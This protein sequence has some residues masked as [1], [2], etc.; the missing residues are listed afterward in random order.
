MIRLQQVTARVGTFQL[1]PVSFE[2][3]EG[4]WWGLSGP[5]GSGKTKLLETVAGLVRCQS[6]TIWLAGKDQTVAPPEERSIGFVYQDSLLFPHLSVRQNIAFAR[7]RDGD[8]ERLLELAAE[9]QIDALLDRRPRQ[10]SGG[11]RQRVALA[12]ALYRQPRILLLDEPLSALD[13]ELR[14][15]TVDLL[16]RVHARHR[17]TTLHTAHREDELQGV[18]GRLYLREGKLREG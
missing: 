18:D 6:G 13:S 2:I 5:S 8:P 15:Q 11:E 4:Q 17:F 10:L 9:L 1:G 16:R 7:R 12:R 14:E 3:P